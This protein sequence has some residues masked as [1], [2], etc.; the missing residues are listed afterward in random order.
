MSPQTSGNGLTLEGVLPSLGL[1]LSLF[2]TVWILKA[3]R[4]PTG[5]RPRS[6]SGV[7]YAWS[8]SAV[9]AVLLLFI[10]RTTHWSPHGTGTWLM[11][12][13]TTANGLTDG[14]VLT[15]IAMSLARTSRFVVALR[16]GSSSAGQLRAANPVPA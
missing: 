13:R 4:D 9:I 7:A 15:A 10:Y 1:L 3:R 12:N 5:A 14:F 2:A 8:W 6:R 16:A 11:P